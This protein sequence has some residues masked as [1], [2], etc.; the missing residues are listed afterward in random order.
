MK[1]TLRSALLVFSTAALLASLASASASAALPEFSASKYPVTYKI[2]G[3]EVL[4]ESGRGNI[5]CRGEREGQKISGEITSA[6]TAT[7]T[8][9]LTGCEETP[10][11][12]KCTSEGAAR[13]EIKT[14]SLPVKPVYTS[15]E[16]KKAGLE[17]NYVETSKRFAK[18]NCEGTE[19]AIKGAV[20]ARIAPVNLKVSSFE[21]VFN[22]TEEFVKSYPLEFQWEPGEWY[23]LE[24]RSTT[25]GM[26][27]ATAIEVKA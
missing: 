2:T 21:V 16:L 4:L 8:W 22:G 1:S 27:P 5:Y 10:F 23:P 24:V 17:F 12:G 7:G 25:M 19:S 13:G 6:T 26:T 11:H 3:L 14:A 20:I 15:K 9:T 18:F